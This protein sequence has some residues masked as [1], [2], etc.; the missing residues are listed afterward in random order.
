[1]KRFI[2]M[3]GQH[4]GCRFAWWD[5]CID[6]FETFD[7][8]QAWNTWDDFAAAYRHDGG[9]DLNRYHTLTPEWAFAQPADD[10]P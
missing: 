4:T 2:D 7:T 10:M 3:R 8:E 1:M 6:K 9:D 5:T